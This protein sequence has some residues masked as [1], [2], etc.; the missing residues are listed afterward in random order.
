MARRNRR[1]VGG[2][3]APPAP[4]PAAGGAWRCPAHVAGTALKAARPNNNVQGVCERLTPRCVRIAYPRYGV[5]WEEAHVRLQ[6]PVGLDACMHA[7]RTRTQSGGAIVQRDAA[8]AVFLLLLLLS[9]SLFLFVV[10]IIFSFSFLYLSFNLF[11]LLLLLL[12][13]LLLLFFL[14]F[15]FFF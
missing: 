5:G 11:H 9:P 8:V 2:R 13:P 6:A 4:L 10:A 12:L 15:L 7:A 1:A 3:V 14:F